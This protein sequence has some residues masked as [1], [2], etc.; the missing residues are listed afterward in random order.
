MSETTDEKTPGMDEGAWEGP[1]IRLRRDFGDRD[2]AGIGHNVT[3]GA[4][5]VPPA[6]RQAAMAVIAAEREEEDR[7]RALADHQAGYEH[8]LAELADQADEAAAVAELGKHDAKTKYLTAR[9]PLA[10]QAKIQ[11]WQDLASAVHA[12][13]AQ[14]NEYLNRETPA[15]LQA[16]WEAFGAF[17]RAL[18]RLQEID[19]LKVRESI[20]LDSGD[21]WEAAPRFER[22]QR[23]AT[24]AAIFGGKDLGTEGRQFGAGE[25]LKE[26]ES[27]LGAQ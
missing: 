26:Y 1:P 21:A 11:A 15:A 18:Q 6:V 13:G 27:A 25:L 3:L 8:L 20:L 16:A 5:G 12:S 7:R 23:N 19:A 24:I 9:I 10:E 14:W 22:S 2:F 17:Q 4:W